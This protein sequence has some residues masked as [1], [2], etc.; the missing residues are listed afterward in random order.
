MQLTIFVA[1]TVL[2]AVLWAATLFFYIRLKKSPKNMSVDAQNLLA[3]LFSS[4]AVLRIEVLDPK[5]LLY[6]RGR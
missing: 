2:F 4:G 5:N 3:D 6:H 1:L